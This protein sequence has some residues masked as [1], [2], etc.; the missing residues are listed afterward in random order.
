MVGYLTGHN[1]LR[2]HLYKIGMSTETDCRLC[3][4]GTETSTHILCECM[5]LDRIRYE[6]FG[7]VKLSAEDI[8]VSG[9]S[10][11]CKLVRVAEKLLG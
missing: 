5:A 2:Y 3:N 7:R 6:I 11:I 10:E 4:I 9:L 1:T 8:K